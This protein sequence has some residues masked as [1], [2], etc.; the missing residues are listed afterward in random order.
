MA[1]GRT[2]ITTSIGA[3]GINYTDGKNILIADS[4]GNFARAISKCIDDKAFSLSVG[5]AA[6]LLIEESYDIRKIT[7]RLAAFYQAVVPGV[8]DEKPHKVSKDL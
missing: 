4:P 1:L 2:V 7:G 8:T 6:R 3:E 5:A